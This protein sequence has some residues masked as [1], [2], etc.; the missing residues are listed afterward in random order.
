MAGSIDQ[1]W[2][3]AQDVEK[4]LQATLRGNTASFDS[5]THLLSRFRADCEHVLFTNLDFAVRHKVESRLWE[6][7]S[8]INSR[9]R[10]SLARSTGKTKPSEKRRLE[11]HYLEFIKASQIFYR[12]YIQ[13]LC[14]EYASIPEMQK[15]AHS[16]DPKGTRSVTQSDLTPSLRHAVLKSCHA[17]LIRLGDLSRYRESEL[18]S[19]DRNW[20][21]AVGYYELARMVNPLSGTSHN[22]LAVIALA[23]GSHLR[24]VYHLYRALAVDEP[25]PT[26]KGNLE[27]EFKKI[28]AAWEKHQLIAKGVDRESNTGRALLT[29]F[30]RLHARCYRGEAFSEHDELEAEVLSQLQVDLKERPLEST[31]HKIVL[32]N[33]AAQYFAGVRVCEESEA[34]QPRQSFFFHLRLNVNTFLTLLLILVPELERLTLH[35][36]D[37]HS[38][39][40]TLSASEKVTVIL[41]RILPGLRHYSSWLRSN[42]VLLVTSLGEHADNVQTEPLWDTYA[43]CLTLLAATFPARELPSIDYLLEE[44]EDT[45]GFKP[46]DRQKTQHRYY[47][48]PGEH[49]CR[50]S[51]PNVERNHPNEEMLARIRDLIKDGL[52]LVLD[53]T[54]PIKV[55]D[56]DTFVYTG[57]N[58]TPDT[59]LPSRPANPQLRESQPESS[60]VEATLYA[61]LGGGDE[62]LQSQDDT[63]AISIDDTGPAAMSMD[64]A[65]RYMVDSLVGLEAEPSS[66]PLLWYPTPLRLQTGPEPL[67]TSASFTAADL[68][69]RVHAYSNTPSPHQQQQQQ[70]QHTPL[71]P[72]I[73][74]TNTPFA[75]Q[76]SPSPQPWPT[77]SRGSSPLHRHQLSSGSNTREVPPPSPWGS[78]RPGS[79]SGRGSGAGVGVGVGAATGSTTPS[80]LSKATTGL[81]LDSTADYPDAWES[82]SR[83][84]SHSHGAIGSCRNSQGSK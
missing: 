68:V 5:I 45:L 42:T 48:E 23:D 62:T 44:D 80:G 69:D 77:I 33:I 1:K 29:W 31:I 76:S 13:R 8:Q 11:K 50:L 57:T 78:P 79:R 35:E 30:V 82:H 75:P 52:D 25:S 34:E 66:D 3:R 54:I 21:P 36:Q 70:Q 7:H 2:I 38:Q 22:Q 41:R 20:G 32:I 12:G 53:E 63:L 81:G 17:T 61:G 39:G 46:F 83:S 18:K 16:F 27:I 51:D 60:K 49:K 19:K 10:K 84:H 71:L 28:L 24:A 59:D 58:S 43:N 9:Y 4:E 72:P 6:A 14:S 40:G 64:A 73:Y 15:V 37:V 65:A 55:L 26:A 74:S 47:T 56:N 67:R